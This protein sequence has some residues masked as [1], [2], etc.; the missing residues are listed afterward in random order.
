M[1]GVGK[2]ISIFE[3]TAAID[4]RDSPSV[5]VARMSGTLITA[6]SKYYILSLSFSLPFSLSLSLS[7]SLSS[8]FSLSD[9]TSEGVSG[10]IACPLLAASFSARGPLAL[11]PLYARPPLL[12]PG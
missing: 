2:L 6:M 9:A 8:S 11:A 1:P 5:Y 3:C 4:R 7:L 12:R 10:I